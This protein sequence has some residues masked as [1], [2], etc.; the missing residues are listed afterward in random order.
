MRTCASNQ[1]CRDGYVCR[2]PRSQPFGALAL[3]N[4]Q[5]KTICIAR[6]VID[7]DL[8]SIEVPNVCRAAAPVVPPID[9]GPGVI[10]V[11]EAGA[12]DA[13]SRDAGSSD[14]ISDAGSN[15]GSTDGASDASH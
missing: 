7:R 5:N 11:R 3:D 4:D 9:A 8:A 6:S 1:D 14:T 12:D 13:G 10:V 15:D 2:D